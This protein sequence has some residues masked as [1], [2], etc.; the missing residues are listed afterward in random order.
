[1][2]IE[3]TKQTGAKVL[4]NPDAVAYIEPF[5]TYTRITFLGGREGGSVH[6]LAVQ[7]T[8]EKI[9]RLIREGSAP[10]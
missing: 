4:I 5:K 9:L 7:E 10:P 3:L 1:M 2:L 8:L 6:A